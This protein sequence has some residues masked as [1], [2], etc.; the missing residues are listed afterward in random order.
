MNLSGDILFYA[1]RYALGRM[2]YAVHDVA[3]EIIRHA[4]DIPEGE[5]NNMI[6]EIKE[7]L[8][9]DQA[10]M[11]MDRKQWEKVLHELQQQQQP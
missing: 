11:D 1:F 8:E 3:S 10:G 9:K 2:T 6:R 4:K 5:R 7:A